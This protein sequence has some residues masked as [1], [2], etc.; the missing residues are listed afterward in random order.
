MGDI[1]VESYMGPLNTAVQKLTINE[2]AAGKVQGS[3]SSASSA[4]DDSAAQA[5]G[6][7]GKLRSEW[8]GGKGTTFEGKAGP[9]PK[10]LEQASADAKKIADMVGNATAKLKA[11]QQEV[12]QLRDEFRQKAQAIAD[13]ANAAKDNP[14]LQ[15]QATGMLEQM[16]AQYAQAAAKIV[17]AAKGALSEG[18]GNAGGTTT[19]S[20]G[21]SNAGSIGSSGGGSGG[22]GGG[23]GGGGAGGTTPSSGKAEFVEPPKN[24]YNDGTK[25]VQLPG[26]KEVEAPNERAAAAVRAAL[27]R[28]GLPY[29]WGG[30]NP[31]K[32]MD[33]SG[34]TQWSY[35]QA[36]IKIPRTAASQTV[37][38]KVDPKDM[39]PGDLLIWTGHVAMYIGDGQIIE[40]P[41]PG[42]NC[43]IRPVRMTN[44]GEKMLGV[45]RPAA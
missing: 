15:Q 18:G 41:Q 42:E 12:Q 38:Q 25:K 29:V 8:S 9:A 39:Q 16:K 27:S 34:L 17:A 23:G 45:F 19:A 40:E 22:T 14:S 32:G 11:A 37:G 21:P 4:L 1:N 26:G 2:G 24:N 13:V 20:A 10:E 3:L 36:G 31:T 35:G 30:T 7:A 28:K 43:H 44:A 33:C 6:D 5:K